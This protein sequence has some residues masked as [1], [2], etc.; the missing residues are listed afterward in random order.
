LAVK[1]AGD[2]ESF[3]SAVKTAVWSV[4]PDFPIVRVT[5]ME[6]LVA[7]SAGPRRF[8][9][10]VFAVFALVALILAAT[11]IY[12]ILAGSVTE[13]TREIGVRSALGATRNEVVGLV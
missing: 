2:A 5:T 3:T 13:R 10:S 8:A 4:A 6:R 7:T 1:T 12:G 9:F 11:G